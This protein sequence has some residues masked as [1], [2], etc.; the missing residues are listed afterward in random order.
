M[1][2]SCFV[3]VLKKFRFAGFLEPYVFHPVDPVGYCG[4]G[5]SGGLE[6]IP[7]S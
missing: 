5:W 7:H 4:A 2:V 1:F 6:I 3:H